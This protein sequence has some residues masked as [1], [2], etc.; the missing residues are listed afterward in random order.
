MP[1][2]CVYTANVGVCMH[3]RDCVYDVCEHA[4]VGMHACTCVRVCICVGV[5]A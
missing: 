1:R 3:I 5:C 4:R 2:A